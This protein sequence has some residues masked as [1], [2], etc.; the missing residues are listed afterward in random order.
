LRIVKLMAGCACASVVS[1]KDSLGPGET[2]TITVVYKSRQVTTREGINVAIQTNDP[3]TPYA[4]V[5]LT[6]LV[7]LTA[8]WAPTTVSFLA[9]HGKR[10]LF[11]DIT[12][13][14][15][16]PGGLRLE[17]LASSSD[18]I[19]A[20]WLGSTGNNK[21]TCRISLSPDC[22]PG[23]HT[24]TVTVKCTAGNTSRTAYIPVYLMI[25]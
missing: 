20:T 21:F 13:L 1:G 2:S 17:Q 5:Q 16:E 14:T 24:E 8:F 18:R 10:D 23:T 6:G 3:K 9:P 25:Q 4:Q 22:P 15:H 19:A 11:N 7:R 12:F